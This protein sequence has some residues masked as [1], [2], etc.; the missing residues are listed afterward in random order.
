MSEGY[1]PVSEDVAARFNA[2]IHGRATSEHAIQTFLEE[3][4]ELIPLPFKRGYGVHLNMVISKLR[5]GPSLVTDFAVL[6]RDSD[7]FDVVLIELEKA[8]KQFFVKSAPYPTETAQFTAALAQVRAWKAIVERD[9]ASI[10]NQLRPIM[11]PSSGDSVS[12]KYLLLYGTKGEMDG[13]DLK[14]VRFRTYYDDHATDF[15]VM[16]YDSLLRWNQYNPERRRNILVARG[17]KFAY[18]RM[19]EYPDEDFGWCGPDALD[20]TSAQEKRLRECGFDL[21]SWKA[22]K[23]LVNAGVRPRLSVDASGFK[24]L[25]IDG[26]VARVARAKWKEA[27]GATDRGQNKV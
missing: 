23:L 17:L 20:L 1:S 24:Q 8:S 11:K 15:K 6:T 7:G 13:N 9:K 3:N 4:S 18:K 10:I 2:L 12:F 16:G 5:L 22:G 19:T 21:D 26:D 25:S 14:R 27:S